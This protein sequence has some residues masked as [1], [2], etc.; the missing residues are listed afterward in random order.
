MKN[1][2]LCIPLRAG[3]LILLITSITLALLSC[4]NTSTETKQA[5]SLD[6][7]KLEKGAAFYQCEMHPDV[8]S[9][10]T[11][12]CSKCGMDLIKVEKK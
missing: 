4:G 5:T 12:T 3:I 8:I 7:T 1:K 6:T 10:K 11:G 2:W 9:D